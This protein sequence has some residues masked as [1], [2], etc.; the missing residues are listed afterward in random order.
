MLPPLLR[1]DV[2]DTIFVEKKKFRGVKNFAQLS[3]ALAMSNAGADW[4]KGYI[5]GKPF[6]LEDEIIDNL[7]RLVF[8]SRYQFNSKQ[9][10]AGGFEVGRR[11]A[12]GAVPLISMGDKAIN[13]AW[14]VM[15][16]FTTGLDKNESLRY[17]LRT[18]VSIPFLGRGIFHGVFGYGGMLG[19]E[20]VVRNEI[21]YYK[22]LR[23]E[24]QLNA[25]ESRNLGIYVAEKR[26]I[27]IA[28]RTGRKGGY[29]W[30][31]LGLKEENKSLG[32]M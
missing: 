11:L 22:E 12:G 24:R 16:W 26:E 25:V 27:D 10:R 21:K 19:R 2:Y 1:N 7:L 29:I 23:K 30:E 3:F 15:K 6:H 13:D 9:L 5:L 8:L 4:L 20:A 14:L 18:P 32:K 28:K 17:N 31:L